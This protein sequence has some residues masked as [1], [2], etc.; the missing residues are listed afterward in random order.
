MGIS[1]PISHP[2]S[3]NT[4]FTRQHLEKNQPL[5]GELCAFAAINNIAPGLAR[6]PVRG[7]LSL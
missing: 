1:S 6:Q 2:G 7:H 3:F 4:T 5:P